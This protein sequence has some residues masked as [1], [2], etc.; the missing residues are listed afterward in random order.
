MS[1]HNSIIMTALER[2]YKEIC[3][4]VVIDPVTLL[5][6][7]AAVAAAAAF[8]R[9]AIT[10]NIMMAR[11]RKRNEMSGSYYDMLEDWNQLSD[12]VHTG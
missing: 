4:P 3:C 11:R 10:M 1:N 12:W 9:I 7:L 2:S 8:L 5:G 6:L